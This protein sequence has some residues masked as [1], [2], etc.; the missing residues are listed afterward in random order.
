MKTYKEEQAEIRAE[1]E[2]MTADEIREKMRKESDFQ[3]ELDNLPPQ[4]HHW[5]DRGAKLTCEG[6]HGY[7]EV[8]K[9]R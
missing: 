3:I 9:K 8:W 4:K 2:T 1:Q 7:H 6:V 5:V